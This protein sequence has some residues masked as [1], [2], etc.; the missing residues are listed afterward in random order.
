MSAR[1]DDGHL[2][3]FGGFLDEWSRRDFLRRMGGAAAFAAF[4]GG[5]VG[6]L[7][8]CGNGGGGSNQA[9]GTPKKGGHVTEGWAF[10]IKNFNSI[11]IQDVYSN[12]CTG[13][14]NEGL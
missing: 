2:E 5:G 10:D 12:I 14:C 9:S 3:Q 7:E 13:L 4:A 6:F 1:P 11:L 8:A